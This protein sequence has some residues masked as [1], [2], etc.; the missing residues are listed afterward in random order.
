LFTKR[1]R[2]HDP[3]VLQDA[4]AF[5]ARLTELSGPPSMVLEPLRD[6]VRS[7]GLSEAP[8]DELSEVVQLLAASGQSDERVTID[9]GMGRGLHYY[10]GALFEIYA[11]DAAGPQLC[12]GGRYDDLTQLLGARQPTP[13]CGF[14]YGLERVLAAGDFAP[15]ANE[16]PRALVLP[17]DAPG[18]ALRLARE[19]R[20]AGWS[21]TLDLRARNASATR[22]LAERQ[23]YAALVAPTGE[24]LELTRLADGVIHTWLQTP[25]PAEALDA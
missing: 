21:A 19:L 24:G 16:P 12:G 10:T 22:R 7:R 2:R 9:L 1:R 4:I 6:L 23:G 25:T 5:V 11:A 18:A 14:S 3:A 13:A 8:L 15:A 17:G 20:A